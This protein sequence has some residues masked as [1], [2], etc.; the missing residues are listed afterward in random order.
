MSRDEIVS[1]GLVGAFALLVTAHV[2]LVAG[3]AAR[4]PRWRALVAL[5]AAPLAPWWGLR[6]G[7]KH[8][9]W[10]WLAS[11][12]AYVAFFLLARR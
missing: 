7:M 3:L 5:I 9:A 4:P 8:R 1:L 11:A 6:V 2:M 10:V 12:V